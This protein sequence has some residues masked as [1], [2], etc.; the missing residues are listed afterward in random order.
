MGNNRTTLSEVERFW[1]LVEKTD[2]CWLWRGGL[3]RGGY[4]RFGP[5]DKTAYRAHRYS[6][7]L[8][9]GE[10]PESSLDVCHKCDTPACVRPDHLFLGTRRDNMQDARAKGR[11]NH[12]ETHPTAKL[13][14]DQVVEIRRLRAEGH[15]QQQLA[16]MFGV[17][18][19][20]VSLICSGKHRVAA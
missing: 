4:G 17:S 19:P 3:V 1:M 10:M 5:K 16:D 6:W 13:T 7:M 2:G 9:H 11:V 14:F 8:A 20:L 12:G 18:A 15:R